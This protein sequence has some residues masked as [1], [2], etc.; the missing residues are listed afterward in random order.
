MSELEEALNINGL[1]YDIAKYNL[2]LSF[3]IG[4]VPIETLCLPKVINT[5]LKK[6]GYLRINDLLGIEPHRINRI[7]KIRADIITQRMR[8]FFSYDL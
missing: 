2:G 3:E 7:S 6:E 4:N 1:R 8:A 5:I